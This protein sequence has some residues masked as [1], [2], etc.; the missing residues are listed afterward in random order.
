M[1]TTLEQW[2]AFQAVV[3]YGGY[4]QAAERL[5]RSQSSISYLVGKLQEQLGVVLL[6][7][8]GRKAELTEAGRVL[9]E[10]AQSLLSEANGIET[11]AQRIG[12]GWETT[13]KLVVDAAFPT[14]ALV[15]TM[16]QFNGRAPATRVQLTEV[17]LSGAEDAVLEQ[18]ADIAISAHVPVGR[19]G[20]KLCDIE[21]VAVARF[22][23]PLHQLGRML[24][25]HDLKSHLH[26]VVRDSGMKQPR[27]EGWLGSSHRWTVSGFP[28]SRAMVVGGLAFAWLPTHIVQPD[29]DAGVLVPLALGPY[30]RRFGALFLI[31]GNPDRIGP[32]T[33]L[34]AQLLQET[35]RARC[36]VLQ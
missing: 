2:R 17:V 23:H 16:H 14:Q 12:E 30:Q 5:H 32:A 35:V 8:Q 31:Y 15:E 28:A 20:Q 22:D 18:Q 27:N 9:L 19:L 6:E 10:Y 21:F 29:L 7:V 36:P 3:E 25:E 33:A 4:A 1:K 34:L 26:V 11:L 24:T 13:L